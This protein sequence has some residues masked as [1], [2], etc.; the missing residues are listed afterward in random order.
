MSAPALT[1]DDL[2]EVWR[3]DM[4]PGYTQPLE[5]EDGGR[6]LDIIA[7]LARIL[8]RAST[9]VMVSTEALYLKPHSQQLAPP[10]SGAI[11]ATGF[12]EIY[13]GIVVGGPLVLDDGDEIIAQF[14]G[15]NGEDED[16]PVFEHVGDSTIPSGTVGPTVVAVRCQRPGFQG[17]VA[18]G[19]LGEFPQRR[20]GE[21]S[22][23]SFN[24]GTGL[25]T[26]DPALG[27]KFLPTMSGMLWRFTSGVNIGAYARRISVVSDTQATLD[28]AGTL[29]TQ[30][31]GAGVVLNLQEVGDF[32]IVFKDGTAGGRSGELDMLA[33]E[34]TLTGRALGEEDDAFRARVAVL[35]DVVSPDSM[36]RAIAAVLSPLGIPFQFIE[37]FE[38]D[39]GFFFDGGAGNVDSAFSDPFA[40]RE[41][42]FYV[43]GSA[44]STT[45]IGFIVVING[46]ALPPE[47][48][49]TKVLAALTT[50]IVG[51]KGHGVPWAVAIE[52]P[53]P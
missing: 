50:T 51:S 42:T 33:K 25:I 24:S 52:P 30:G 49:L 28:V 36:I 32:R 35:P 7:G 6:G 34:R 44:T 8:E 46:L 45:P 26:I 9:A 23:V 19:T 10:A 4:D 47:P 2:L 41:R 21:Y 3:R 29:I 15:V 20:G 37:V 11:A 48:D 1:K 13:R 5:N 31:A 16:A 18:P 53:V 27:D 43:G 17:N 14:R 22:V 12:V 39:V 38:Q 40:Y